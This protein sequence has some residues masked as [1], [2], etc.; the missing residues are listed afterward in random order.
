MTLYVGAIS[1]TSIDGLDLALVE[2]SEEQLRI[3]RG[4]TYQFPRSLATRLRLLSNPSPNEI[5]VLGHT[6]A[7]LGTFIGQSITEFLDQTGIQAK[8]ISAIGSHGQTIR[9]SP[10]GDEAFSLQIGDASRI[11]EVTGLDTV[12]DFRSRDIAAG[13]EGAPLVPEFHRRL[14]HSATTDRVVLNIGGIA[15]VTTLLAGESEDCLGFDTGPGNALIDA[16]MQKELSQDFDHDGSIASSG[17]ID[18]SLLAQLLSDEWLQRHP[19]KSTGKEHF[20]YEYLQ[21]ALR[22]VP[23]Q[24]DKADVVATLTEFSVMSIR[25]AIAKW[26]CPSGELVACG[27]G[28]L[29]VYLM[30]R[31]TTICPNFHVMPC[32]AL[33]VDGDAVEAAAFAYLAYLHV[34]GKAGNVPQVT[35]AR[36]ARILGCLYPA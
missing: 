29:N 17:T 26:C 22:A 28:R 36:G 32:E 18:S 3:V 25:D 6:H 11:A 12:G 33:R 19:P 30:Q 1:G 2:V 35:G 23:V 4:E 34:N 31:L 9:H 10:T 27:G 21:Q 20:S 16:Y 24:L 5:Q 13:G 14:F 15:N 8:E 7:A